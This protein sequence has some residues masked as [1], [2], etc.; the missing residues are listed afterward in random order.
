M[1]RDIQ[2]L[3]QESLTILF[4]TIGPEYNK[5]ERNSVAFHRH[6]SSSLRGFLENS[7][8]KFNCN[9]TSNSES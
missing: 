6:T 4:K 5:N 7:Q 8:Q 3:K 1:L 9:F 2:F